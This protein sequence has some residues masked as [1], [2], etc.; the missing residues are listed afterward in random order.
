MGVAKINKLELYVHNSVVD[1]VVASLQETGGCEIISREEDNGSEDY[2][3]GRLQELD[4]FLSE[5]RFILRFLEPY[6]QDP[7]SPVS[8]AFGEKP[9][10]SI[11]DLSS[12]SKKTDAISVSEDMR[13]LERR[14]VEIR[15]ELSQ[16]SGFQEMLSKLQT[17]EYPLEFLSHGTEKTKGIFGTIPVNQLDNWQ[18]EVQYTLGAD[19]ESFIVPVGEK[20]KEAWA[21]LFYFVGTEARAL[22]ICSRNGM[23]RIDIPAE[24]TGKVPDEVA[25]LKKKT[26][27][28]HK[29]EKR[30]NIKAS[31]AAADWVPVFRALSDY[32]SLLRS[33]EEVFE[34]GEF[35][36]QVVVLKAWVPDDYLDTVY[37]NLSEYDSLTEV[38]TSQPMPEEEPPTLMQNSNWV[39]P[40]ESLTK[41]Y[42]PPKYGDIDPTPLLAPFFFIFFGMCL[43]DGGYGILTLGF[44]LYFVRKYKKMP[45]GMKQFFLLFVFSGFA[46]IIVGALTG[47]WFGNMIDAFPFLH[48][49]QPLKNMPIVLDPMNDPMTFLGISLAF[50]VVQIVFGLC[51]ALY[52][53]L[54]DGDYIAAFG[55]H[56]GWLVF[57]V[58][59][60]LLGGSLS[61]KLSPSFL[62]A[63][64]VLGIAGALILIFTQGREKESLVQKALSG[65]LS[66]YNVTAYLGDV[67]SYSRLLALGLATSA[68]AMIINMLS[69]LATGIPYIGWVIAIVLCFGG[70]LFSVAVN[71]LGAFV[72]SLRLQYVEFFSKFYSGGGKH[73]EPL[74]YNTRFI[75]VSENIKNV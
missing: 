21:G 75:D 69:G 71:V 57:L 32:W 35:T 12:L 10:M 49:L 56:G 54:R 46:S 62:T 70:H 65:V 44:F 59:L 58:G 17:L 16:I 43:G 22:E 38:I 8:R 67:L 40:F 9:S 4:S 33:R 14:L 74:A 20:D 1:S 73:F 68:I 61:G 48:Y 24:L 42:G 18:N 11:K 36:D 63:G 28:L 15:S 34:S 66:L 5:A 31:K 25:R 51:V 45:S 50:G 47:S 29:E 2:S 6:Y 27:S 39:F 26:V 13:K 72:H 64:K 53:S 55:D 3:S 30:I 41:L 37:N 23:S 52:G 60:M 7:I 19:A